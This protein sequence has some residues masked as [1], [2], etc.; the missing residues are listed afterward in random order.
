MTAE[1]KNLLTTEEIMDYLR[2]SRSTLFRYLKEGMPYIQVS[3]R[4]N[5]YDLERV[6]EWLD[7]K[8]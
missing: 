8:K 6:N 4:K 1:K 2:I 3:K 5:L 7:K